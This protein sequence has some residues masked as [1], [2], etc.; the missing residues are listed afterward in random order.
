MGGDRLRPPHTFA[1]HLSHL[2]YPK[3]PGYLN[4]PYASGSLTAASIFP[5][6]R[7]PTAG[8]P[9]RASAERLSQEL[10]EHQHAS[11][12]RDVLRIA[13]QPIPVVPEQFVVCRCSR[14][15][16][17]PRPM[18]TNQPA[19]SSFH[20]GSIWPFTPGIFHLERLSGF[21]DL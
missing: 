16:V 20:S 12:S 3:P 15:Y 9:F 1:S 6:F 10:P 2:C 11:G 21:H 14:I 5:R 7:L 17:Q 8:I 4:H 19:C 13:I 18:Q